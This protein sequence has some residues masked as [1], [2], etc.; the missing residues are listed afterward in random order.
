M[1][2]TKNEKLILNPINLKKIVEICEKTFNKKFI[3]MEIESLMRYMTDLNINMMMNRFKSNIDNIN[4]EIV[5]S[6]K[7]YIEQRK[8]FDLQDYMATNIT[9]GA[10]KMA[11]VAAPISSAPSSSAT[12]ATS[13]S[14]ASAASAAASTAAITAALANINTGGI[15][16]TSAERI[17][18][19][20]IINRQSLYRDSNILIDSRYQNLANKNK[21]RLSFTIVNETKTKI[22]GSGIITSSGIIKDVV[23][24]EVF[25][26]SIPYMSAADNYY[27]KITLSILELASVSFDAYED[28]QFH[29]MFKAEKNNNLIDLTP[30]NNIF[31]FSKPISKLSDFTLRFG[32]PLT[33]IT[34]DNDRLSSSS[35]DYTSNPAVISFS[36]EHNLT[37]DDIIYITDFNTN[38]P[39]KDLAIINSINSP[40]G[41]IC[42][43]TSPTKISINIDMN[44][45]TSPNTNLSISVYF[46]SKRIMLPMR[47]RYLQSTA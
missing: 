40:N 35:I 14:A 12:S 44:I 1:S 34:F 42:T 2:L 29:F 39:A 26:F 15:P 3:K 38:D 17:E 11:T 19:A 45:V 46:G 41:H 30:I 9:T 47:I 21:S 32:S 10:S 20:K 23:E 13:A 24:I 4:N 31:R 27:K 37:T 22:P 28:S 8:N 36:E 33:P 16:T 18:F 7:N 43:R 6:Y 25:P 5:K